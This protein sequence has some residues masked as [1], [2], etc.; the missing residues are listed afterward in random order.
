MTE[1]DLKRTVRDYLKILKKQGKIWFARLNSGGIFPKYKGR[2]YKI[3]LCEE[4]T[5]DYIVINQITMLDEGMEIEL[6]RVIF[7]EL[8]AKTKQTEAQREFQ[9]TVENQGADYCIIKSLEDLECV[10]GF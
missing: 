10:L 3:E 7:L 1:A 6:P 5:A 9:K 8:K 2:Y 4:G